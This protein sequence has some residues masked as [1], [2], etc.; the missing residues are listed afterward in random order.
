V[1]SFTPAA[2]ALRERIFTR[3]GK[4]VRPVCREITEDIQLIFLKTS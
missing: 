2:G 3:G 4:Q 1:C